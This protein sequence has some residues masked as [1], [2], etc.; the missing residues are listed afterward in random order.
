[1]W[2]TYQPDIVVLHKLVE[3][4]DGVRAATNACQQ[5]VWLASPLLFTLPPSLFADDRLELTNHGGVRVRACCRAKNVVGGLDVGDPITDGF[6]GRVFECGCAC[7]HRSDLQ[8]AGTVTT[9]G[10]RCLHV[11]G[12]NALSVC[13]AAKQLACSGV[14]CVNAV[15]LQAHSTDETPPILVTDVCL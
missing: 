4:A 14:Q 13:V 7:V 9:R 5:H 2:R 1:M 8:R 11:S 15:Q 10:A 12:V 6:R 3:Q